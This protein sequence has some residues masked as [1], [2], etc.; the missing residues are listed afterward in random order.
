MWWAIRGG[1]QEWDG[2]ALLLA[3]VLRAGTLDGLAEKLVLQGYLDR[4]TPAE[5]AEVYLDGMTV[6]TASDPPRR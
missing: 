3:R 4:L 5:L 6:P 1:L 2:P